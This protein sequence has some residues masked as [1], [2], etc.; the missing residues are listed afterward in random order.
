AYD[1]D[2]AGRI[3]RAAGGRVDAVIDCFGGDYVRL[4]VEDLGVNP[5]R[6]DTIANFAAR[7]RFGVKTE[8]TATA[9]SAEVL[10]QLVRMIS[11]GDLEV[12]IA[13]SYPLDAVQ[14]AYREL[15]ERHTLG[16]IVL[17]P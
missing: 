1:G 7:E 12:P 4:A 15:E 13:R 16:K 11:E 5:A 17:T 8:G 9:A 2:V 10:E 6:I 3:R 14:D